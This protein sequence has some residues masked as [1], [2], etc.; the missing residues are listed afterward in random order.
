L[1]RVPYPDEPD[2]EQDDGASNH[3]PVEDEATA[4]AV[5]GVKGQQ[6]S[7]NLVY[8]GHEAEVTQSIS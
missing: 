2:Q 3:A 6:I 4:K 1:V 8:D 5:D 7:D